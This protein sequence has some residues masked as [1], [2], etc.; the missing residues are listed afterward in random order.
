MLC[1]C[2]F[3]VS[4]VAAEGTIR[5]ELPEDMKGAQLYYSKDDGKETAVKV[6]DD[7]TAVI[8]NLE[9]GSYKIRIPDTETLAFTP[10]EVRIPMWSI[11]EEKMMYDISVI[12]K[13]S[14]EEVIPQTGDDHH[15]MQYAVLGVLSLMVV[16]VSN[17][18]YNRLNYRR[19]SNT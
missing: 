15:G 7:A 14:R 9:A 13:Y 6:D 17:L 1:I 18:C 8:S 10:V 4:A 5:V 11:E 2:S 3:S 12:P 16:F 19:K